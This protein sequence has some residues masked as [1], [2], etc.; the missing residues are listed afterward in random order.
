[1]SRERLDGAT[2]RLVSVLTEFSRGKV[3]RGRVLYLYAYR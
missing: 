1:V 2:A 3:Q